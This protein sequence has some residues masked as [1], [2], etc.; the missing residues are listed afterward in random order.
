[1]TTEKGNTAAVVFVVFLA[2]VTVAAWATGW[3]VLTAI[4]IGAL[5]GF[6]L[7]KGDLCGSSA[8][9]E[10]VLARDGRKVW[11]LWVAIVVSMLGIALGDLLGWI[12]LNPKPFMW[13][14]ALVGGLVFGVGMVLAGGCVSGCLY[15]GAAGNLN[16]IVALLAMPL[17]IGL[18]EYGPL[19]G[20]LARLKQIRV[21]AADG[22]SVTLSSLTGLPF[23]VLALLLAA[24]TLGWA[25]AR[26]RRSADPV[27]NGLPLHRPWKPWQAGIAIG[28]L[29]LPAYVSSSASGR[30]YPLGVT[31]G[32]LHASLLVTDAPV[33]HVTGL[34]A[35]TPSAGQPTGTEMPPPR[36]KVVWWLVLLV[37]S[38][39]V[40]SNVS[41]RLSGQAR[42]L[43]KPPEQVLVAA[44]GGL[45]V[46]AGAALATG[47]VIGN[48]L[49]GWALMSVGMVL[50]AAATVLANWATTLLYLRGAS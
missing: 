6:F 39:M 12:Q 43:P 4:P 47:C 2:A 41:G 45:L 7:Q 22:G 23:W 40:G 35:S 10:V 25:T 9:S 1:V 33:Q 46:G 11:G 24:A 15:K 34:P 5:F 48:I 27:T 50:F 31:H 30:N 32:V 29:A 36:K 18:V 8:F 19:Q 37:G 3:W 21:P 49:S 20:T 42:L 14:G 44:V 16:S 38:L 13:A 28:L 26:R 17:G